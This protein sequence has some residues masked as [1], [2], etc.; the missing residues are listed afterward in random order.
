[1]QSL[2]CADEGLQHDPGLLCG[3]KVVGYD[4]R[5]F[6]QLAALY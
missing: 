6:D 2:Y 3:N 4:G 5:T 1:M